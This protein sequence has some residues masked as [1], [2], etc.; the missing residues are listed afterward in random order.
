MQLKVRR[1]IVNKHGDSGMI[2]IPPLFLENMDAL[3]CRDVI[4]S[5]PDRDHILI[6][7]VRR[8]KE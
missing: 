4:L 1:K 8:E 7:I 2:S 6:E 3:N 5:V